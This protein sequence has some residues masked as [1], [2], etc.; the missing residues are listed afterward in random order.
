M[1]PVAWCDT[2]VSKTH[3]A[4][5]LLCFF[6]EYTKRKRYAKEPSKWDWVFCMGSDI[7]NGCFQKYGKTPQII[8][9]FSWFGTIINDPFWGK[10]PPIFGLKP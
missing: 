6:R 7:I 8:H 9:F 3:K 10:N 1:S 4:G 2:N 5:V